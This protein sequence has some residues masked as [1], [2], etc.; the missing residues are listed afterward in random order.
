MFRMNK[1]SQVATI[2]LLLV[3]LVLATTAWFAIASFNDKLISQSKEISEM[4]EEIIF[5]KDY[6]LEQTKLIGKIALSECQS[7]SPTQFK[8]IFI[9]ISKEKETQ[10]RYEG[11]GN[12]YAKIRN[13]APDNE[14]FTITKHD[15]RFIIKIDKLFVESKIGENKIVRTYDLELTIE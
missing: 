10:F 5:N 15:N 1:K 8:E 13:D 9:A 2:L 3:A 6:V 12:F 11:A 14:Q 4:M 7:C